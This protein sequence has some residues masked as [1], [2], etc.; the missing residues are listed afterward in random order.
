[1]R[2]LLVLLLGVHGAIHALGFARAFGLVG[3]DMLKQPVLPLT[4]IA[5]LGAT[6]L[7]WVAALLLAL[8]VRG[9]WV[10]ATLGVIVSQMLIVGAWHDAKY[11]TIANLIV[12][13]PIVL[14]A[15]DHRRGSLRATYDRDVREGLAPVQPA[16]V[17]TE[18]ELAPLPQLV[19]THLR[20][21]GVVGRPR[22]RNFHARFA[23]E[24]RGGADEPW[25]QAHADQYEFFAPA[26]RLFFMR[27]SRRGVPF[28]VLH[29]Y[30]GD[31][32]TMQA[33]VAGL[34]PVIDASGPEMTQSETV[35]LL[36]DMCVFAPGA[37]V[38]APIEWEPIDAHTVRATLANA[39]HRVSAELTFDARGDLVDFRSDDRYRIDGRT[40]QRLRWTTPLDDYR[41]FDGV[42][43]PA[44]GEARWTEGERTWTYG[45]FRLERIAYNV[46][47]PDGPM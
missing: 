19:R 27:A 20:R 39:G 31:R 2:T 10:P 28:D 47:R 12:L 37:L 24:M 17:V 43:L 32:A 42:R 4:G 45:R 3:P 1:M 18:A 22:V 16:P 41:D 26:E 36:N 35:T 29:R 5:W 46:S 9:W 21:A 40:K 30:I 33:R 6:A 38:D 11:G 8:H 23:A 7:L 25:M 14:A 13:V 44:R 15:L 34:V